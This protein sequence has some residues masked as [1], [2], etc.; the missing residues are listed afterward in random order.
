[1][2]VPKEVESNGFV[3]NPGVPVVPFEGFVVI[4]DNPGEG[5]A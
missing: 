1:M 4:V 2:S 5:E 3:V